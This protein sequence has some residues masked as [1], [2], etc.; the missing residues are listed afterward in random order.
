[1]TNGSPEGADPQAPSLV[2]QA[3]GER[4]RRDTR[5]RLL[6]AG[7][8]G[9]PVTITIRSRPAHAAQSLQSGNLYGS[10]SP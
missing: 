5:R 8:L 4:Q 1:M 3:P 6:K 9:V 7:L 2:P 10:Q